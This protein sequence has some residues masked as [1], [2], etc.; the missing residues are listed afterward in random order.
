M[1][2]L[3]QLSSNDP[4][5]RQ[6]LQSYL[7]ALTSELSGMAMAAGSPS[8]SALYELAIIELEKIKPG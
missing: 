3:A 5:S 1:S 8:A 7:I 6:D 4:P 2:G